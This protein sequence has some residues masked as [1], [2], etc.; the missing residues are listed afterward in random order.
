MLLDQIEDDLESR[1]LRAQKRRFD[2]TLDVP[3][4][5][6]LLCVLDMIAF[7]PGLIAQPVAR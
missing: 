4:K 6:A 1:Y 3:Q 2:F 5:G 7:A